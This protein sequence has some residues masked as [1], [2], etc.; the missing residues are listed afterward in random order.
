MLQA[1]LFA[2]S[3]SH[4]SAPVPP[5]ASFRS[6]TPVPRQPLSKSIR[7]CLGRSTCVRRLAPFDRRGPDQLTS[8]IHLSSRPNS[9]PPPTPGTS[10]AGAP[11]TK[12][13]GTHCP[14]SSAVDGR[15]F[16]A[17]PARGGGAQVCGSRNGFSGGSE[18]RWSQRRPGAEPNPRPGRAELRGGPRRRGGAGGR[19]LA[20]APLLG[21]TCSAAG[22]PAM[23]WR[24]ARPP[25]SPA[26]LGPDAGDTA[27]PA[28]PPA[29]RARC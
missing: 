25:L 12:T 5:A 20:R 16:F 10:L 26:L 24:A 23:L 9:R 28:R 1:G 22:S 17:G 2:R 8:A 4:V 19:A 15:G 13:A 7:R 18:P 14:R 3:C 6:S 27:A 29:T 21:R 11:E